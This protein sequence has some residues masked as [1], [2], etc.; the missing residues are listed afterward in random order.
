MDSKQSGG[1]SEEA[2]TGTVAIVNESLFG[3]PNHSKEDLLYDF[4]IPPRH[5]EL[6]PDDQDGAAV[7]FPLPLL[8]L[9]EYI[10]VIIRN[11]NSPLPLRFFRNLRKLVRYLFNI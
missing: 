8:R 10:G 11:Y 5:Y 7:T 1:I 4:S 2:G 3:E 9:C 6:L